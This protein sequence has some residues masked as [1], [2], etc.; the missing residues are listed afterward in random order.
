VPTATTGRLR[1]DKRASFHRIYVDG[2]VVGSGEGPFELPCGTHSVKV[3]S[4]SEPHRVDI[5]CGGEVT[6]AIAESSSQGT[7]GL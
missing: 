4:K 6:A 2:K 1:A 7:G 3:G 5:P